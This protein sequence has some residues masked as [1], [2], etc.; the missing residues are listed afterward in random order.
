MAVPCRISPLSLHTSPAQPC[1]AQSEVSWGGLCSHPRLRARGRK[2]RQRRCLGQVRSARG[3][4]LVFHRISWPT[5]GLLAVRCQMALFCFPVVCPRPRGAAEGT[6]YTACEAA[7]GSQGA[8]VEI[9]EKIESMKM[10]GNRCK[11]YWENVNICY[12]IVET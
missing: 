4:V 7:S 5:R 1:S 9:L 10:S 12:L 6:L 2:G 3:G 11:W 8:C